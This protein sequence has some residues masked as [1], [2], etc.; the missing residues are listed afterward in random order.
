MVTESRM[1][2]RCKRTRLSEVILSR[3]LY[4]GRQLAHTRTA[5]HRLSLHWSLRS[6]VVSRLELSWQDHEDIQRV[7]CHFPV[8]FLWAL[9]GNLSPGDFGPQR[10]RRYN[11]LNE[12]RPW[13]Q[14]ERTSRTRIPRC[15]VRMGQSR[16]KLWDLVYELL[17][18]KS[19]N[20]TLLIYRSAQW[21]SR[22]VEYVVVLPSAPPTTCGYCNRE[23]CSPVTVSPD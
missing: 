9:A 18:E 19:V 4:V 11:P 13:S 17:G 15:Q 1:N 6:W 5:T 20:V 16:G 21:E 3:V 2:S 12:P 8:P 14:R 7:Y 22:V 10:R 23:E